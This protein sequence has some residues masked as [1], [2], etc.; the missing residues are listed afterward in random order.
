MISNDREV[1][2]KYKEALKDYEFDDETILKI[3]ETAKDLASFDPTCSIA[4]KDKPRNNRKP[5][6]DIGDDAFS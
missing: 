4:I 5:I 1:F 3:V 2:E 6:P